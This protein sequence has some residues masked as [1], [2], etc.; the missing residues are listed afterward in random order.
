MER[1]TRDG[2]HARGPRRKGCL[3]E[4]GRGEEKKKRLTKCRKRMIKRIK[5][6]EAL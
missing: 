4:M 2:A 1:T 3:G 6:L 5:G